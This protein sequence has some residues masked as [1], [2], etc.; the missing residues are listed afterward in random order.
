MPQLNMFTY[1]RY[2]TAAGRQYSNSFQAQTNKTDHKFT[3][4]NTAEQ[5]SHV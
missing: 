1:V 3:K 4:A 2:F 5:F